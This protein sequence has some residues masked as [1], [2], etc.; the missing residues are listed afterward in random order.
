LNYRL[1]FLRLL[2]GGGPAASHLFCFAKKGNPK[3]AT[4]AKSETPKNLPENGKNLNSPAAQTKIF[5]IHFPA[6]F[7]ADLDGD[8]VRQSQKQLQQQRQLQKQLQRH[9]YFKNNFNGNFRSPIKNSTPSYPPP[10]PPL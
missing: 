7:P 8:P 5:L 2:A 9:P 4:P 10:K 1:K 6:N 3:K